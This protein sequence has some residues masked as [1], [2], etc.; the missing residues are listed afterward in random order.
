MYKGN[1]YWFAKGY[2]SISTVARIGFTEVERTLCG[3]R[4]RL[5]VVLTRKLFF[6]DDMST[7]IKKNANTLVSSEKYFGFL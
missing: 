7:K 5:L 6:A 2:F 1:Y 4:Q 3:P